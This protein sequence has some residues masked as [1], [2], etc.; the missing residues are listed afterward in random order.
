MPS[1]P[2]IIVQDREQLVALLTEAAEIEH[3][4]MCCYLFAAF[5]LKTS[6]DS[7]LSG[8]QLAA[9]RRWRAVIIDVAIEEM[10]HLGLVAN[11]MSAIGVT[12]HFTRPNFPV[13]AGYH[14]SGVVIELARFC[15][16]T[17]DH[18]VFLE[19]PEGT[20]LPD[21]SG[22][23]ATRSYWRATRADAL[24]PS[25]QDFLTVGHLY[26]SIGEGLAQLVRK[27]G[28]GA[29]FIGAP[30]AQ[31]GPELSG[32]G[33]LLCVTDLASAQKA[34]DAIVEQGEGSPA[35]HDD[36][37]YVKFCRLRDELAALSSAD[38]AFDPAWPV[39]RNPVMR[40]PPDPAGKLHVYAPDAVRLLDLGNAVYGL[41][42]RC[43]M[44]AFG[45]P[46]ATDAIRGELYATGLQLMHAVVPI[47]ERLARLPAT[48]DAEVPTA[49]LTFTLPRSILPVPD[50]RVAKR[51]I[52][53]RAAEIARAAAAAGL[54]GD[55]A[56]VADDL[57]RIATSLDPAF[58]LEASAT[59]AQPVT[60][61][62]SPATAAAPSPTAAGA[63]PA[64]EEATGKDVTIR[65]EGK[66]CIHA[67]FCVL[68]APTVFKANTPGTW[69]YPDTMDA[70]RLVAVAENCPS[71]AITYKRMDGRPDEAPPPVNV[72][73][74]RENGPYAV[75]AEINLAGHGALTR[76]TL[77][78]CGA[79]RNKP[80]CDGSHHDV[81][82]AATG[83][84]DTRPSE[85]LAP[86][87]GR[88]TIT[89]QP[90]GPLAVAGS[91]EICSGTGRTVDRITSARLC[92]C[93][94]SSNK[95]F[96]DGTHVRIGFRSEEAAAA[97][98][99]KR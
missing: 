11:L 71:G 45:Q 80:F 60:A 85:P 27:L 37:H 14:P 46:S 73:R 20:D 97:V 5:S 19:R 57:A 44:A 79:S 48:P 89:P 15:K 88:L 35:H 68:Q 70:E 17:I 31:L 87:D 51:F 1:E 56:T 54:D 2:E 34:I 92:R 9:T 43:L 23:G 95:P 24:V 61:A 29:V 39:A 66:R 90:N 59:P 58:R 96:C 8:A 3:G 12:P 10:L 6:D 63:A 16:D 76:A 13:S 75:H 22:M 33:S 67:R 81:G 74:I 55:L 53:E 99:A 86:R 94:G 41:M 25:A 18:F 78:R 42:L 47:A 62:A 50:A 82:F 69:I 98:E 72:L 36:S 84:P 83:E 49:G 40:K 65:F 64:I 21:G 38:P 26:R 32:F 77:C 28:E 91:L 4:L 30:E 7:G 52:V 93:G